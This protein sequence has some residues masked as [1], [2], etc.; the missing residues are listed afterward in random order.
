MRV[1]VEDRDDVRV[2]L[3]PNCGS[4][5][6][7]QTD[8]AVFLRHEDED[9]VKVVTVTDSAHEAVIANNISLN[10]SPRR[11][12]L[13]ISFWCEECDGGATDDEPSNRVPDLAI[14]QHK[15]ETYIEWLE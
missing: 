6:L 13:R 9:Q 8:V 4:T 7:H 1:D 3:C 5:Y 10:P 2:L 14:Y 12:G 11:Y 15:G